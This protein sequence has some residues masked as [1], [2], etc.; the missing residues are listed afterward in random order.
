MAKHRPGGGGAG[1]LRQ[2]RA[3]GGRPGGLPLR[4]AA[5][6][7][8]GGQRGALSRR[9]PRDAGPVGG[10]HRLLGGGARGARGGGGRLALRARGRSGG[11]GDAPGGA[12]AWTRRRGVEPGRLHAPAAGGI[13]T[14]PRRPRPLLRGALTGFDC[15][16]TGFRLY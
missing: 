7:H 5:R 11:G 12:E 16:R 9:P 2:G 13:R 10:R 3:A 1:L 14:C 4:R 8:G 6:D 15:S